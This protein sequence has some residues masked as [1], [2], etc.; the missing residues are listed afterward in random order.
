M[1]FPFAAACADCTKDDGC[2]TGADSGMLAIGMG[3]GMEG[4]MDIAQVLVLMFVDKK[5]LLVLH[6]ITEP[7]APCNCV[8]CND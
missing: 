2:T 8:D 4:V 6:A 3:T 1:T 5:V 7:S